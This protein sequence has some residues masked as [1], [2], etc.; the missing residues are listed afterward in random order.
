[1]EMT[2]HS[3]KFWFILLL[4]MFL[5]SCSGG[6]GPAPVK[7]LSVGP[8]IKEIW[9][10]GKYKVQQSEPLYSTACTFCFDFEQLARVNNIKRPHPI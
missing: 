9:D 6:R 2:L 5:T 1:M 8:E 7:D 10:A 4:L 3:L